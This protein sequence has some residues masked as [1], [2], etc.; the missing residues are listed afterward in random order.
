MFSLCFTY[1][2]CLLLLTLGLGLTACE[3]M[4]HSANSV[5]RTQVVALGKSVELAIE[6]RRTACESTI[7]MQCLQVTETATQRQFLIWYNGIEGFNHTN[8]FSYVINAK[9]LTNAPIKDPSA[10]QWQ[11][12]NIIRQSPSQ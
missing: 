8:G 9:P 10:Q 5:A 3:H 11:L 6:P 12:V 2:R 7:P 4:P 1:S